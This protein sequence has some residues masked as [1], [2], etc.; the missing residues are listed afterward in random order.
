MNSLSPRFDMHEIDDCAL[1]GILSD[2]RALQNT[3]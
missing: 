1:Q 3:L 2:T